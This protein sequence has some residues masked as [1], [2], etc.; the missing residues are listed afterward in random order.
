MASNS[1][2]IDVKIMFGMVPEE[3]T[4]PK[5]TGVLYQTK[6]NDFIYSLQNVSR[7]RVQNGDTITIQ[8]NQKATQDEIRLFL[9]GSTIGLLHQRGV[10]QSMEVQ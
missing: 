3:L 9:M 6:Q 1:D 5:K 10:L 2:T 4:N 8:P 7:Y